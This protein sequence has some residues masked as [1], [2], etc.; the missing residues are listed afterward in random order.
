[1]GV[2]RRQHA[3]W[4]Q[5]SLLSGRLLWRTAALIPDHWCCKNSLS[6]FKTKELAIYNWLAG[7]VQKKNIK[8]TICVLSNL[9][10]PAMKPAFHHCFVL[11]CV[12][13][14]AVFMS[15]RGLKLS[16]AL[17]LAVRDSCPLIC[18]RPRGGRTVA[19]GRFSSQGPDQHRFLWQRGGNRRGAGENTV[20]TVG[21]NLGL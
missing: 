16:C 18:F 7:S 5:R 9:S 11:F 19:Q 15:Q 17:V 1:M 4:R 2:I 12:Q 3:I 10:V 20:K 21:G 8:S 6:C 13:A 14:A